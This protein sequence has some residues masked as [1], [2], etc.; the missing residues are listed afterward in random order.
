M[1]DLPAADITPSQQLLEI[2]MALATRPPACCCWTRLAA[3]LTEDQVENMAQLIRHLQ[4]LVAAD[5]DLDRTRGHHP[6]APCGARHRAA[7]GPLGADGLA[8]VVPQR[9]K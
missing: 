9:W 8:A 7:P 1:A 3:G 6:A 4:E 5:G 2:G